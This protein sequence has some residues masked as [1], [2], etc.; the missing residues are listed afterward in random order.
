MGACDSSM[1]VEG[2]C[3]VALH[4][5]LRDLECEGAVKS[6][7][8]YLLPIGCLRSLILMLLFFRRHKFGLSWRLSNS[9]SCWVSAIY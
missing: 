1:V 6:L 5:K 8:G 4:S 2:N 7:T 3:L 9:N